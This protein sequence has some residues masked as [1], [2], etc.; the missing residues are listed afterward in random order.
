MK[1][2]LSFACLAAALAVSTAAQADQIP[3][4]G[5][6]D[7]RMKTVM[8]DGTNVTR[9]VG[10]FGYSTDI[11][12][13][14]GEKVVSVALG[15]TLAWAVA[16][17]ENHLFVKPREPNSTT[18]MTVITSR[19][20]YQFALIGDM[21][22][23]DY[24]SAYYYQ[25]RFEYPLE[26]SAARLAKINAAAV[27]AKLDEND[28]PRNWDYW[29]CGPWAIRPTKVYDDGRFTYFTFPAA[30]QVPAVY[31]V[32]ADGTESLSNGTMRGDQFVAF[33]TAQ[34]FVLRRGN[35]VGCVQ[36]RAF[37]PYGVY[38]PTNTTSPAVRRVIKESAP[39][40]PSPASTLPPAAPEKQEPSLY[41]A[42]SPGAR[43]I[44]PTNT[45]QAPAVLPP[46]MG[47]PTALPGE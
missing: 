11:Q 40:T 18:N 5:A 8:Y 26:A 47:G 14:P 33:V 45:P 32:N 3:V 7:A 6:S 10:H 22:K 17:V 42:I 29:G 25:V 35:T 43:S 13:D 23:K 30:Q 12:F 4:S 2:L 46:P 27:K 16:P 37:N 19:R 34:K 38:T 21:G 44:R 24:R 9:V 36:N 20:V 15:D 39:E 1:S 28:K 31:I 41:P